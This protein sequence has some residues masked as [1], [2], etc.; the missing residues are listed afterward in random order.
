M[1]LRRPPSSSGSPGH[2]AWFQNPSVEAA[3]KDLSLASFDQTAVLV[4]PSYVL[5]LPPH[6]EKSESPSS[7]KDK[8][9]RK[10][11]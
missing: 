8:K 4:P 10:C 9:I 7:H 2:L 3:D 6:E 11:A 1:F 5:F